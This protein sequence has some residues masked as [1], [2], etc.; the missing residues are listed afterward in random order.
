MICFEGR[1]LLE[2]FVSWKKIVFFGHN[3]WQHFY[4]NWTA[5]NPCNLV[6]SFQTSSKN[7]YTQESKTLCIQLFSK[8][9]SRFLLQVYSISNWNNADNVYSKLFTSSSLLY[10]KW[11]Q[12]L[13][14]LS[15]LSFFGVFWIDFQI[16]LQF[17]NKIPVQ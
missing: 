9:S 3:F 5:P 1:L 10:Q 8:W 16:L 11:T 6:V 7:N 2:S 13:S 14:V 17:W 12:S 15:E 4:S